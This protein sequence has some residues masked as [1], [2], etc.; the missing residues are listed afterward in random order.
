LGAA[1]IPIYTNKGKGG[2]IGLLENFVLNKSMLS[3][4]EQTDILS[5]LQSL[6]ALNVPDVEPVLKKLA[7]LFNKNSSSWIDVD[8]SQ[9]GSGTAEKE[10]FNIIKTAII[11]RKLLAFDYYSSYGEKTERKIEPLKLI[12]KE[13]AWYVYGFCSTKNDFRMFK[14]TRIK[15]LTL[16]M[17]TFTRNIPE[18]I[19]SNPRDVVNKTV[20]F[21]LKIEPNMAF[22][23][24]DEFEQECITK[25]P[26]GSFMVT[27]TF[28]E[29]EWVYSYILSF[30]N[31]AEIME[32]MHIREIIKR[33]LEQNLEKYL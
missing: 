33:K 21:V 19:R 26:D 23:V 5:S 6:K 7:I 30:G 20:K 4:K 8:F 1:G 3:E 29:D 14:I 10:K 16:T 9:W 18:N 22:R 28:P 15:N 27:A 17:G 13:Q 25:N 12:F 24:Y 11:N 32:P 2:G 31:Y